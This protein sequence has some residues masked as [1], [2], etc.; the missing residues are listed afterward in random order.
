MDDKGHKKSNGLVSSGVPLE[1]NFQ[2]CR[3]VGKICAK[4]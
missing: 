1:G 3:M 2:A 4:K